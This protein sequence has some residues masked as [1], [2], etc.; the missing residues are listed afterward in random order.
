MSLTGTVS[1][2]EKISPVLNDLDKIIVPIA[3]LIKIMDKCQAGGVCKVWYESESAGEREGRVY[4][5]RLL[6]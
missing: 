3:H 1:Q 6:N 5:I 4:R 2:L